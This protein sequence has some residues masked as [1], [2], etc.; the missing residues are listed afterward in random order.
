LTKKTSLTCGLQ[1]YNFTNIQQP[2]YSANRKAYGFGYTDAVTTVTTDQLRY[3]AIPIKFSYALSQTLSAGLGLN[4][5][6]LMSAHTRIDSYGV[7]DGVRGPVSS[8]GSKK[9]FD[10]TSDYNVMGSVFINVKLQ[11]RI[12]GFAELQYGLTDLFK[13]YTAVKINQRTTGLRFGISFLLFEK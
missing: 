3:L 1:Y 11:N 9:V 13:D 2:Y 8:Q 7:S 6:Y 5:A 10:G 12:S 4:A